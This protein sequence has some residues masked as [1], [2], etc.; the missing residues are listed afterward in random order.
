M[1]VSAVHRYHAFGLALEEMKRCSWSNADTIDKMTVELMNT[2]WRRIVVTREQFD[3]WLGTP[4]DAQRKRDR[5]RLH[6][7]MLLRRMPPDRNFQRWLSR[8]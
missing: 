4:E 2:R 7:L 6:I 5:L 8:R 3:A 1:I